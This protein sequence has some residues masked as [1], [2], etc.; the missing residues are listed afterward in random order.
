[1]KTKHFKNLNNKEMKNSI[2][3]S[4]NALLSF[5]AVLVFIF[6]VS[7]LSATPKYRFTSP[8]VGEKYVYVEYLTRMY[9]D[10]GSKFWA[11]TLIEGLLYAYEYSGKGDILM[12]GI[13]YKSG[14]INLYALDSYYITALLNGNIDSEKLASKIYVFTK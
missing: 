2:K 8:E 4:K 14:D 5:I 1:M 10:P 3:N 7:N 6:S 13:Y 12:V 9:S 11:E